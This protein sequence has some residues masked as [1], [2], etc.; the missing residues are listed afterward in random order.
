MKKNETKRAREITERSVKTAKKEHAENENRR[1]RIVNFYKELKVKENNVAVGPDW[2]V[3]FQDRV[4]KKLLFDACKEY[5]VKVLIVPGD[6]WDCDNYTSFLK[7]SYLET[8]PQE[9][10]HAKKEL[11][12]ITSF[13]K[14]TYFSRG[15]HEKRWLK[16]NRGLMNIRNLFAVTEVTKNYSV[17]SDD[18][19]KLIS[20]GQEWYLSHPANYS[21]NQLSVANRL[22]SKHHMN[23]LCAHGH[24]FA[25]GYDRSGKYRIL[26]GGGIFDSAQL[27][28]LRNTTCYPS[29]HSGF[30]IIQDGEPIPFPGKSICGVYR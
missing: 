22:A 9:V 25:Q 13:F 23:V 20:G 27:E 18:H 28:Y 21:E 7:L 14:H 4:M 12:D 10:E 26:D 16:E 30:Y 19:I 3:P 17:T 24:Q 6:F 11:E 1:E 29:V 5:G 15:N 8:F 2:H